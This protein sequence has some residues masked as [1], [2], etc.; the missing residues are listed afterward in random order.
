MPQ[1]GP[2]STGAAGSVGGGAAWLT[3]LLPERARTLLWLRVLQAG[4]GQLREAGLLPEGE[5]GVAP[6]GAGAA[7]VRRD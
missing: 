3:P 6:L 2:G 7:A 5:P 4:E 1:P